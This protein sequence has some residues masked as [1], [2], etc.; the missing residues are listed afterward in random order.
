MTTRDPKGARPDEAQGQTGADP[1]GSAGSGGHEAESH[2]PVE[3]EA[4]IHDGYM[5]LLLHPQGRLPWVAAVL[6]RVVLGMSIVSIVLLVR[7]TGNGYDVAGVAAAAASIGVALG[8]PMWGRL[9][10]RRG[11]IV[12]LRLLGI[13]YTMAMVSLGIVAVAGAPPLVLYAVGV[14]AGFSFPP[15]SP[16]ARVG[17]RRLYGL[18]LRD[19]AFALDSV[20]VEIGFVVG[21]I[22]AAALIEATT[23][24]SGVVLAGVMMLAAVVLFTTTS[25]AAGMHGSPRDVRGGALRVPGLW[26]LMLVSIMIAL[27]FGSIDILAPALAEGA[28]RPELAGVVLGA[29]AFGSAVGGFVYGSRSWPSTR[30]ARLQIMAITITGTFSL[31]VFGVGRLGLFIVLAALTGLLIAP[32]VVILFALVDDLAPSSVVTEALA[33]VNT[34]ITLGAAVGSGAAGALVERFGVTQAI[35]G[36]AMG[37]GGAAVAVAVIRPR[38][39]R[40]EAAI[41]AE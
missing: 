10:D 22:L 33:W 19:R 18:R 25:I 30:I 41:L 12:V 16:V 39:T 7:R 32:M 38:L 1:R 15:V 4:V 26:E 23:A 13:A 34:A 40:D 31:L 36:G 5:A 6:A 27:A 2:L 14:A 24:W 20:T 8:T 37:L 35:L 28:G 11:P 17:W 29:F 21:P 9:I 3:S